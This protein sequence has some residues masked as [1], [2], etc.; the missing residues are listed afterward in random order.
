MTPPVGFPTD[1]S[2]DAGDSVIPIRPA[3]IIDDM[4]GTGAAVATP[5]RIADYTY[6][7]VA[8]TA[9]IALLVTG[10]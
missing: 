6:R 4:T 5:S 9:G 7:I 8:L 3:A 10:M 2:N 1:P